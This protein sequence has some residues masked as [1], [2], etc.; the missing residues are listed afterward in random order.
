MDTGAH[1][2][3]S[4]VLLI[5][6]PGITLAL[7]VQTFRQADIL[8]SPSTTDLPLFAIP[9]LNRWP[10]SAPVTVTQSKKQV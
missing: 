6:P 7:E 8:S 4:Q 5:L 1:A 3:L 10:W 9:Q 2:L